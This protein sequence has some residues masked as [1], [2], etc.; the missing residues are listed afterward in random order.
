MSSGCYKTS[1]A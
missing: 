1:F